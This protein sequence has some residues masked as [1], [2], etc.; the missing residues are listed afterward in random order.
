VSP[1]AIKETFAPPTSFEYP[2][3]TAK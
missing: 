3:M 1:R 2:F